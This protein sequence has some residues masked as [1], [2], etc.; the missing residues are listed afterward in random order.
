M[1]E[2]KHFGLW[3]AHIEHDQIT[4]VCGEADRMGE[5]GIRQLRDWAVKTLRRDYPGAEIE[6]S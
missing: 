1:A 2:T 4:L 6:I 3:T 5:K